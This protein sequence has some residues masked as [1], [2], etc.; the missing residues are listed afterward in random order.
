MSKAFIIV[1]NTG[2]GKTTVVKKL[3][4]QIYTDK[5]LIYDVQNEYQEFDNGNGSVIKSIDMEIEEFV[6]LADKSK[7]KCIVFEESTIFFNSR[8]TDKKVEKILVDKR[9]HFNMIVF[10]FHS[11][12]KV[13]ASLFDV[14]NY[15]V[16]LPTNDTEELIKRKFE[17]MAGIIE[18]TQKT[19][20]FKPI[21]IK[22]N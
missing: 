22:V 19:E 5:L 1:G 16:L 2:T 17:G 20:K 18:A 9:H 11:L 14:S 3:I 4:S 7:G 21:T 15:L 8:G 10:V 6:A 13:P 12:R